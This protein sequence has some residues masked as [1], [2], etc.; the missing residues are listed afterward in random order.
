MEEVTVEKRRKAVSL[1][2]QGVV[3]CGRESGGGGGWRVDNASGAPDRQ[4]NNYPRS[5]HSEKKMLAERPP[6]PGNS[7]QK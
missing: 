3:A 1:G 4:D 2:R 6:F 7:L 5:E